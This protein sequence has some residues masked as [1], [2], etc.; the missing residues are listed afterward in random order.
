[1][2]TNPLT[3]TCLLI[4]P[5][6]V[7][8][9]E[10]EYF[11]M[12]ENNAVFELAEGEVA[13]VIGISHQTSVRFEVVIDGSDYDMMV[14]RDD[15]TY[16]KV[17]GPCMVKID[18]GQDALSSV[19]IFFKITRANITTADNT[20]TDYTH[21]AGW[22]FFTEYPWVFSDMNKSWYYLTAQDPGIFAYNENLPGD[23]WTILQGL[24]N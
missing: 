18:T 9:A 6:F 8:G 3:L 21:L 14:R 4:L 1:M 23:N 16:P 20:Q 22:V 12:T 24:D 5:V 15:P 10:Y 11:Q 19:V 17:S 7:S 13:E 2:K